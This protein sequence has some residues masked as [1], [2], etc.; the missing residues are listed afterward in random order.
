MQSMQSSGIHL[1]KHRRMPGQAAHGNMLWIISKQI[2]GDH[3]R[4]VHDCVRTATQ[5][6]QQPCQ[7]DRSNIARFAQVHQQIQN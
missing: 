6:W 4:C 1:P 3:W 2:G 7:G 5:E